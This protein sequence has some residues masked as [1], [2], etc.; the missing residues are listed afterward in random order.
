MPIINIQISE[1][2]TGEQKAKISEEITNAVAKHGGVDADKVIILWND[3][4]RY[5]QSVGGKMRGT[6]ENK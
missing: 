2:R 3:I 1:G 4:P 6:P 5:N